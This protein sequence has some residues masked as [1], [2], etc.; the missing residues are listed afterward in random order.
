MVMK[1]YHIHS[2][3]ILLLLLGL[4]LGAPSAHAN[5]S[6]KYTEQNPLTVVCDRDFP[7]F[8]FINSDGHPDGLNVEVMSSILKYL[9]IPHT[10]IM[11]EWH[12]A[13]SMFE[14]HQADIIF[15][16]QANFP[17]SSYHASSSMFSYYRLKV[18]FRKG[19]PRLNHIADLT[20]Q[21]TL[22]LKENDYGY[23]YINSHPHPDFK[24]R[25][26]TP[27]E[28]LAGINS[29][30]Y[31]YFIWGAVP[32]KLKV[33]EKVGHN[34]EFC[35]ID[36]P[37]VAMHA[38]GHDEELI[39][40][41]DDVYARFEQMGQLK[42][43]YDRWLYPERIHANSSPLVFII[44]GVALAVALVVF[45]LNQLIRLRVRK[46]VKEAVDV[47][48]MKELALSL[49][50]LYVLETNIAS[51]YTVNYHGNLLP[52]EGLNVKQLLSHVHPDSIP[53]L[54][55]A[56][57]KLKSGEIR[58]HTMTI[59]WNVGTE[60]APEWRYLKGHS[61][62]D[63]KRRDYIFI[64]AKDVTHEIEEEKAD[65]VVAK[66]YQTIF[67]TNLIAM[68]FYDA[69]GHFINLNNNMRNLCEF[70]EKSEMYFRE[71]SLFDTSLIRGD[72]LPGS[73]E[74]FYTCQHMS[75]PELG[76]D[77]YI[78]FR[79]APTFN[80]DGSLLYYIVTSRDLTEE[81]NMD[82]RLRKMDAQLR[83]AD[84]A[85]SIY[86]RQLHYLL[87]K[88]DMYVWWFELSTRHIRFSRSL[89]KE[90]F[91]MSRE[92]Y[93]N[94]MAEDDRADA[95]R[96]LME[97]MMK[98]KDFNTVHR[99]VGNTPIS[100][101]PSWFA[102]SGVP[103]KNAEGLLTG[104]FG[105]VRNVTKLMETQEQLKRETMRAEQSGLLKSAYVANLSH[106]IR[107]PLNAIVGFSDLLQIIKEP[108]ERQE[109]IRIIR[110]NCDMLLRLINDILE[111]SNM[112]QALAIKPQ[113][114][115]FAQVFSDVC[116][117]LA[118]R[119]KEPAVEFIADHP[120]DTFPACVD[121]GR[122]QQV[123]TNFVTN[124]I[125]YTHEGHIR[126]GYR[127]KD[128]GIYIYCE[129]TGAGIPKDK[130]AAVFERFVKLNDNIKGTGLGLAICNAIAER[131]GGSIGVTSEGLGH[132]STFWIWIPR[133]INS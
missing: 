27:R 111:A 64:T 53:E 102:L 43:V 13:S 58:H 74:V 39:N 130:Q 69:D 109:F 56:S 87:D 49:S 29:G 37:A 63:T 23:V 55:E 45:V 120:Y 133:Y 126:V 124:A 86:E 52:P 15:G 48:N 11:R 116:Q 28:A 22:I 110:N 94:S 132:G 101:I 90:E 30:H 31:K 118:Q 71:T 60:D 93:I 114:V 6:E 10:F 122:V 44:I 80:D 24:I 92:E 113:E 2:A 3:Y 5:L 21:D 106:E 84:E 98:G 7:P 96:N 123:I 34:I 19:T 115:D 32:M 78:E 89:Q 35:D 33:D 121:K 18:A 76:L 119:V 1:Q 8:E 70:D 100:E 91:S 62:I 42:P 12:Q 125:K 67:D 20:P 105:I 88:S 59:K 131:C 97:V 66:E 107:T 46:S 127:E 99:F 16:P 77:K 95:D 4:L 65:R 79:I 26:L 73:R 17:D 14:S 81:R 83:E 128:N 117:T 72:Y 129:D 57:R 47:N 104:Y 50:D 68:S 36:I 82:L 108:E 9:N 103:L 112:G 40:A 41:I 54:V 25:L 85:T 38:I 61:V 75:Y 51:N